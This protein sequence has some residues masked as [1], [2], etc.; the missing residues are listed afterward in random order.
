MKVAVGLSQRDAPQPISAS[1]DSLADRGVPDAPGFGVVGCNRGPQPRALVLGERSESAD[2]HRVSDEITKMT[3]TR[4]RR[5]R[6]APPITFGPLP[7]EKNRDTL[8]LCPRSLSAESAS[9]TKDA[10]SASGIAA[11]A[12]ARTRSACAKTDVTIASPAVKPAT[13]KPSTRA[14]HRIGN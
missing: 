2:V 11:F 10:A 8:R 5:P 13:W 4:S 9:S 3:I 7:G 6:S 14:T 1:S 12:K